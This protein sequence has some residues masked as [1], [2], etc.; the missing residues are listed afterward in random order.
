MEVEVDGPKSPGRCNTLLFQTPSNRWSP[1]LSLPN[2]TP[3]LSV[4][5]EKVAHICPR[6]RVL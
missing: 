6:S 5:E 2:F 4:A 1:G 3:P